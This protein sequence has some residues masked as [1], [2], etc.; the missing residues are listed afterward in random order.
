[1]KRGDLIRHVLK[2]GCVFGREG[3]NHAIYKNPSNGLSTGIPRHNEID[4]DLARRICKELG[5]KKPKGC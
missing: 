5:I 4:N 2:E 3:G 1:M